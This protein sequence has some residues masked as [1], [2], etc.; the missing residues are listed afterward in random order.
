MAKLRGSKLIFRS[1]I[2]WAAVSTALVAV[3]TT[4][5][6]TTAPFYADPLVLIHNK[7]RQWGHLDPLPALNIW[8]HPVSNKK[9]R[10]FK[11]TGKRYGASIEVYGALWSTGTIKFKTG[12]AA[13]SSV[14][15]KLWEMMR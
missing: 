3:N 7:V 2:N 14:T 15:S 5:A 11:D 12:A 6:T 13:Q 10:G 4:V 8:E 9:K 1:K